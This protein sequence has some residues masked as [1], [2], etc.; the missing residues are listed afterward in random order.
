MSTAPSFSRGDVPTRCI[1]VTLVCLGQWLFRCLRKSQGQTGTRGSSP[2]SLLQSLA[3]SFMLLPALFRA[4]FPASPPFFSETLGAVTQQLPGDTRGR[5]PTATAVTTAH[6]STH[7]AA[8]W[9]SP[10]P[11]LL[12]HQREQG[13]H[14]LHPLYFLS[15][16]F[17]FPTLFF[18]PCDFGAFAVKA[19][20]SIPGAT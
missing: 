3:A 13:S 17:R 1:S 5:F 20:Q 10:V 8:V 15:S 2:C 18:S 16:L 14:N 19:S 6:P 9:F 4:S 11:F 7:L 12:P